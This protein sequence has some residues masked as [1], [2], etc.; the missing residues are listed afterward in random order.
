MRVCRTIGSILLRIALALV[1]HGACH[2]RAPTS[3]SWILDGVLGALEHVHKDLGPLASA[4]EVAAGYGEA[5]YCLDLPPL[6]DEALCLVD[7]PRGLLGC[8]AGTDHPLVNAHGRGAADEKGLIRHVAA[9]LKVPAEEL[10]KETGGEVW[11]EDIWRRVLG[12]CVAV[13]L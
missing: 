6:A 11:W 8:E 12:W 7:V 3:T 4:D 9:T 10:V 1:R 13:G 2:A 5:W